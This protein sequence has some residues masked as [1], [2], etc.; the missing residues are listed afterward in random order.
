MEE[1]KK[2]LT[3]YLS[4]LHGMDEAAVTELVFDQDGNAKPDALNILMAKEA[5]RVKKLKGKAPDPK[6]LEDAL[7]AERNK[8]L[9]EA[10]EHVKGILPDYSSEKEGLEFFDDLASIQK[11]PASKEIT[12]DDVKKSKVYR[13]M[14]AQKGDELKR[15]DL[16]WKTKYDQRD[17]EIK[18]A[19]T[20]EIIDSEALKEFR[21]LNPV[22]PED[23]AKAERQI[24]RLLLDE[25][26]ADGFDYEVETS[27]DGK[28]KITILKD[29]KP[30][31]D[32]L[33]HIVEFN[34]HI[35]KIAEG[36]FLFAAS[37]PKGA[38]GDPSKGAGG[39]GAGGGQGEKSKKFLGY[40]L[41]KPSSD[42]DWI[43]QQ[44]KIELDSELKPKE[45]AELIQS[46]QA[47]H[48]GQPV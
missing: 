30:L 36:G 12:E 17:L 26:S 14:L 42:D 45:K 44:E 33:G 9:T 13:D 38:G 48:T 23:Q 21:A 5:D 40:K 31:E 19:Q 11:A 28:K 29:G 6:A 8:V 20:K 27:T 24:K 4:K 34:A 10:I 46:L 35:K 16:E 39:A 43:K 7:K 18:K 32:S 15:K 22:L 3:T 1:I 41:V 2:F 37:D 47:L 25:L